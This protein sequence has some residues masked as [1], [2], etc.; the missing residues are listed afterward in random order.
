MRKRNKRSWLSFVLIIGMLF[1]TVSFPEYASAAGVDKTEAVKDTLNVQF[2]Q[3]N[4]I[5][6]DENTDKIDMSRDI[7]VEISFTSV[8]NT[9]VEADKRIEKGDY[10]R[11]DLGDKLKFTGDDES[12]NEVILPIKDSG[13]QLKICDAIFTK[14]TSTG[15]INVKFDFS[16]TDDAVFNKES[17]NVGAS[18]KIK[19]DSKYFD[20]E[21]TTEKVIK[22]LGK[23]FKIGRVDDDFT[24]TKNGVVDA[25]NHKVDWTIEIERYVKGSSPKEYLSLEGFVVSDEPKGNIDSTRDYISGTFKINGRLIDDTS[26]DFK[27]GMNTYSNNNKL[28]EYMIKD[29]DL[30]PTNKGKAVVNL[31]TGI[32]FDDDYFQNRLDK[33]YKNEVWLY[34]TFWRSYTKYGIVDVYRI[35]SKIGKFDSSGKKI[36]WTIY[37]NPGQYDLGDV[38]VSDNLTNDVMGR[39][40]QVFKSAYFKRDGKTEKTPVNPVIS[41]VNHKFTIP[42]VKERIELV[43]E[44][45]IEAD[46]YSVDFDNYADVWWNG[47]ETKKVKLHA[48]VSNRNTGIPN[49]G[50]INKTANCQ[51]VVIAGNDEDSGNYV[52][53][54]P[55]WSVSANQAAVTAPGDYYMYDTFIF[56]ND[57]KVN[58][59]TINAANGFSI[60]KVGDNS[61]TVLANGADFDKMFPKQDGM[62]QRLSNISEPITSST[63]GVTHTVYEVIKD[64]KVVGHILE[65]KLVAGTDNFAKFKSRITDKSTLMTY[66]FGK[67]N[68]N[69]YIVKF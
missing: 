23:D 17:A 2:T 9:A 32:N 62:H 24:I 27:R 37:L 42:D 54:E 7:K 40:P 26:P 20:W 18:L 5:I 16:N 47:N 56:D 48:H 57:I 39:I 49:Q 10:V 28:Y 4:K 64:G 12:E 50:T 59:D 11:L 34:N 15:N 21:N 68:V 65:L 67:S 46:N 1:T 43:I 58:A 13:S 19:I 61:V 29:S 41:G 44:T 30:D 14:N 6:S 25:K 53:A 52:G 69:N 38:T 36:T 31:S 35:G 63:A 66:W 55:E 8:F 22:I 3:D 51:N 33:T 60:R 45:E